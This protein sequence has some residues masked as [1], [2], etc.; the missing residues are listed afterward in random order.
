MPDIPDDLPGKDI[1]YGDV[2][3]YLNLVANQTRWGIA[4]T[5]PT[6]LANYKSS[7]WDPTWNDHENG[8]VRTHQT[9]VDIM[10]YAHGMDGMVRDNCRDIPTNKLSTGD[11]ILLHIAPDVTI[12][13]D[14][15]AQSDAPDIKWSKFAHLENDIVLQ[16]PLTPD[17]KKMP[18]GNK[19]I[20]FVYRGA[21]GL[22]DADIQWQLGGI[23]KNHIFRIM[24][25]IADVDKTLYVKALYFHLD[26][27]GNASVM[28]KTPII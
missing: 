5:K 8:T 22:L 11:R 10:I 26:E 21:A 14:I 24:H 1:F 4:G 9:N 17:S 12:H 23:A 6:A 19:A 3:P 7:K 20:I 16:N 13:N 28:I 27:K 18:Y 15:H 25:N 2:T